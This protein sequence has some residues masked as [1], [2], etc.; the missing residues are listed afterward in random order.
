MSSLFFKHREISIV[1]LTFFREELFIFIVSFAGSRWWTFN[2]TENSTRKNNSR[3]KQ[4]LIWWIFPR[5]CRSNE[6]YEEILSGLRPEL[7]LLT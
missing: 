6:R 7:A 4:F 3:T 2:C 5:H 1:K